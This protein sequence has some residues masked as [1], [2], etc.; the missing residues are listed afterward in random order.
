[1]IENRKTSHT[2]TQ[3][4]YFLHHKI[5]PEINYNKTYSNKEILDEHSISSP[6]SP[7]EELEK[8]E[9]KWHVLHTFSLNH[10]PLQP[11]NYSNLEI[12][13]QKNIKKIHQF[14]KSI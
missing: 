8:G 12:D 4:N 1:M 14:L 6:D 10:C 5:K 11:P 3:K 13:P 9:E 7:I 2:K